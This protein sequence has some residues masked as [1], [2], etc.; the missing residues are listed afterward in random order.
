MKS[1]FA[2][3]LALLGT[4][5]FAQADYQSI[6]LKNRQDCKDAEPSVLEAA[7]Y[8]LSTPY[9]DSD[10]QRTAALQFLVKWMGDTPDYTFS[11]DEDVGKLA[12]S[13]PV[14]LQLYM[15]AMAKFCLENPDSAKDAHLVKL[16]AF[17]AA[18]NYVENADNNVAISKKLKVFSDAKANGELEKKLK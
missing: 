2:L 10:K 3:L 7:N 18:L 14:F 8:L 11:L 6:S 5:A 4:G 12:K 13:D 17:T 15:T 9:Q 16:G 1:I